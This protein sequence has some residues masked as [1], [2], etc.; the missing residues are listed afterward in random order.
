MQVCGGR[1][2]SAPLTRKGASDKFTL[3]DAGLNVAETG[4]S[5]WMPHLVLS[6]A[7]LDRRF[8]TLSVPAE[9]ELDDSLVE[10]TDKHD[11]VYQH[12]MSIARGIADDMRT[13]GRTRHATARMSPTQRARVPGRPRE[14]SIGTLP[15]AGGGTERSTSGKSLAGSIRSSQ[16][17]HRWRSEKLATTPPLQLS[18]LLGLPGAALPAELPR[19][20]EDS[21]YPVR[22]C[23]VCCVRP[24]N[25]GSPIGASGVV[26]A[27]TG[28]DSRCV[29][30]Y[31][32]ASMF[33]TSH[34]SFL[35]RAVS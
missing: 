34:L 30:M 17:L 13:V 35:L 1:A 11:Q 10:L 15:K 27:G 4:G 8:P 26:R 5:A 22:A 14:L 24:G 12:G 19:C 29:C 18:L 31:A 33:G 20:S 3:A 9:E 25:P 28:F 21:R 6:E 2:E 7:E 16:N 23:C 32:S